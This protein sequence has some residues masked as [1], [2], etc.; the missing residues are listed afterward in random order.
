MKK[1][2]LYFIYLFNNNFNLS[3]IDLDD[4]TSIVKLF[5]NKYKNDLKRIYEFLSNDSIKIGYNNSFYESK[6]SRYIL[7]NVEKGCFDNLEAEDICNKI[8]KYSVSISEDNPIL[9]KREI[10]LNTIYLKSKS[11]NSLSNRIYIPNKS[12]NINMEFNLDYDKF[13]DFSDF[14]TRNILEIRL[15]YMNVFSNK[16][17]EDEIIYIDKKIK[18]INKDKQI[19]LF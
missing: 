19:N 16:M 9:S 2:Y 12:N 18:E 17:I 13:D 1:K 8:C 15:F 3:Y 6:I 5:I 10:D 11:I 14:C 7:D 4:S